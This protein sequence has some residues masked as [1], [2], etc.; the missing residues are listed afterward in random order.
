MDADAGNRT[1]LARGA[2]VRLALLLLV[3]AVIALLAGPGRAAEQD[4]GERLQFKVQ[5]ARSAS[6]HD[7]SGLEGVTCALVVSGLPHPLGDKVAVTLFS[8]AGPPE[9]PQDSVPPDTVV[10]S[11]PPALDAGVP[12]LVTR[13]LPVAAPQQLPFLLSVPEPPPRSI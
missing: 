11:E 5:C 9:S 4:Q 8:V 3:L 6:S 13:Q 2:A 1:Q 10:A 7:A 12:V